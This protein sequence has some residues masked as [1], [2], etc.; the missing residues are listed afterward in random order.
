MFK[1]VGS[2]KLSHARDTAQLKPQLNERETDKDKD[3]HLTIS[4]SQE[5]KQPNWSVRR[6]L[7]GN[8]GSYR[9]KA[10]PV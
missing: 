2:R 6:K 9:T 7:W 8:D 3:R 5:R 4:E 1:C 10:R